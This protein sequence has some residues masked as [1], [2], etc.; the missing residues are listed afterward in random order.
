[1]N[2][3]DWKLIL[4]KSKIKKYKKGEYIIKFESKTKNLYRVKKG[5]ATVLVKNTNVK[6]LLEH[7]VF[8]DMSILGET[9]SSADVVCTSQELEIWKIRATDVWN[10]IELRL[11]II[12]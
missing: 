6:E 4:N 1:M 10:I 5:I 3:E 9:I 12:F 8:G 7:D 2:E 11:K